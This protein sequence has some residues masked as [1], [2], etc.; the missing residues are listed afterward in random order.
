M[1]HKLNPHPY[2]SWVR[3]EW[4]LDA[5]YSAS[6]QP[7]IASTGKMEQYLREVLVQLELYEN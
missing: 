6:T 4:I 3:L 1:P 5:F 7:P 2:D